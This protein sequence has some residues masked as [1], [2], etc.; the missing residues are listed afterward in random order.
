MSRE[1]IWSATKKDFRVDTFRGQGPG[2]Q[3]R[4]K[5]DSAVRITHIESGLSASS[6]S[7]RSQRVNKS[8]AFRRL[9]PKLL[10]RY[11]HGETRARYGAGDKVTRS[12]HEPKDRVTDHV[13]GR[14]FSFKQTVGKGDI[15]PLIEDRLKHVDA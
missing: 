2:G 1:L 14:K 11:V 13:T 7:E 10:E 9:V 5:T 15:G 8:I 12:Y 4:N 3:H 6:Q